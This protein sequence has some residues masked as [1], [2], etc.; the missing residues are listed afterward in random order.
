MLIN[1]GF[2][3]V[4]KGKGC[5]YFTRDTG[6]EHALVSVNRA[7]K[8]S[9]MSALRKLE[10]KQN[11]CSLNLSKFVLSNSIIHLKCLLLMSI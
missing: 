4:F 2:S 7:N 5:K 10:Q 9:A 3:V 6:A 8:A 11:Y 1:G